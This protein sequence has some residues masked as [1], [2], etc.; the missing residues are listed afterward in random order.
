M[1]HQ[2]AILD[3]VPK[4]ASFVL[5]DRRHGVTTEAARAQV[6]A[7][8]HAPHL[9]VG[10]GA[11]LAGDVDGFRPIPALEGKGVSI[12]S[13]P[14]DLLMRIAGDDPG[15]VLHRERAVLAQ[16]GLFEVLERTQTFMYGESRDLTGYIDGTENPE[17]DDAIAAALAA[18]GST[19]IAVQRWVHD[20][21]TFQSMGRERQ[22]HTIGRERDSNEELDDAPESAHVKRTAQ[23]SF[24][25][26]AFVVR[27]SMPWRDHRGEGLIFI[28]QGATL[29]PFEALLR[30]M[31]GLEDGIVDALFDFTR[32][33]TGA[34]FWCPPLQDGRLAF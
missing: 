13:T 8:D 34:T 33:V 6:R 17:G 26:E 32:P 12:P 29:D 23:E 1:T 7:L 2:P 3:G 18:D 22:D 9:L 14:A 30:R 19:V 5:L 11:V 25:P 16:L 24:T 21:D 4:H 10:L 31:V 20:L 15:E 28:A 27:R